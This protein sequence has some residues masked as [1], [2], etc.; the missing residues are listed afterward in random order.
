MRKE[1]QIGDKTYYQRPLFLGQLAQLAEHIDLA[2]LDKEEQILEFVRKLVLRSPALLA[3]VLTDD[4]GK[5]ADPKWL[6]L[7]MPAAM[8]REVVE[9]FLSC[10]QALLDSTALVDLGLATPTTEGATD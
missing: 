8:L 10:N 7:H 6:R 9:D 1:Y 4:K 3:I 2:G 5:P